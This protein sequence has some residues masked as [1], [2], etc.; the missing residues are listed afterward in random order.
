[1]FLLNSN[2]K[3]FFSNSFAPLDLTLRFFER[4]NSRS[5]RFGMVDDMYFVIHLLLVVCQF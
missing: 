2:R 3:F 4:C 5:H 1:M